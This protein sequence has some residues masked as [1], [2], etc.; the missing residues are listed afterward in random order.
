[1]IEAKI[2]QPYVPIRS[3]LGSYCSVLITIAQQDL[4]NCPRRKNLPMLEKK[5]LK[6]KHKWPGIRKV[7]RIFFKALIFSP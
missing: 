1:M 3:L 4:L 2:L 5:T 6:I 7:G